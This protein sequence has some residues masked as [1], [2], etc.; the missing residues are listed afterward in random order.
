MNIKKRRIKVNT[1]LILIFLLLGLLQFGGALAEET[2]IETPE[3]NHIYGTNI[4][5]KLEE[6]QSRPDILLFEI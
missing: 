3:K 6:L 2:N 1:M 4:D 5:S